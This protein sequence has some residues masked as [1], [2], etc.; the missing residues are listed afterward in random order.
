MEL[1]ASKQPYCLKCPGGGGHSGISVYTC[2]NKK[3]R[4]KGGLS[5]FR[6]DAERAFLV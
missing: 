1:K 5:F 4:G 6:K 3:K 2:V